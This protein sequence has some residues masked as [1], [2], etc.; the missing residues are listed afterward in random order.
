[1]QTRAPATPHR[2]LDSLKVSRAQ[3]LTALH[4]LEHAAAAVVQARADLHAEV[5]ATHEAL[6]R[7]LAGYIADVLA[8][9]AAEED[10]L[11]API[12]AGVEGARERIASLERAEVMLGAALEAPAL[13]GAEEG[14]VHARA[15]A[16]AAVESC[17]PAMTLAP[18][19]F[20]ARARL[21]S[22]RLSCAVAATAVADSTARSSAAARADGVEATERTPSADERASA[23]ARLAARWRRTAPANAPAATPKLDTAA[24]TT[25]AASLAPRRLD[26]TA[27]D[28]G[29]KPTLAEA[30]ARYRDLNDDLPP[31][32]SPPRRL[33]TAP[34]AAL[35]AEAYSAVARH[36]MRGVG[37]ELRQL[38]DESGVAELG[39]EARVPTAAFDAVFAPVS[40][41]PPRHAD[42][43]FGGAR[44]SVSTAASQ[45]RQQQQRE[46]VLVLERL[47]RAQAT[48][49]R[50]ATLDS[51]CG[52]RAAA[53]ASAGADAD[54]LGGTEA[55]A[56]ALLRQLEALEAHIGGSR[57]AA[58]VVNLANA[59]P[60][61]RLFHAVF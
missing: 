24:A 3:Q 21:A 23:G 15:R 19:R 47:E 25:A 46:T 59:R 31:P 16:M 49:R 32:P 50:G 14:V 6:Q 22:I 36:V 20:G 29:K 43:D 1:L 52:G 40:R 30:L 8:Q 17:T 35:R 38:C 51:G 7:E 60:K 39:A 41:T 42:A 10:A 37:A 12:H 27:L 45:Q 26:L 5:Y 13:E 54:G 44:I 48:A 18:P 33:R 4:S 9:C 28:E 61:P 11:L 53:R 58:D 57:A 34:L 56:A 55:H 2:Q